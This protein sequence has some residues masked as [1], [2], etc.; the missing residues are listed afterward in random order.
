LEKENVKNLMAFLKN[1]VSPHFFMN[2]LNNIHALVDI[3]VEQAKNAIIELSQLM[4][5]MLYESQSDR[6]SLKKELE[7]VKSYVELMQLRFTDD[8]D[9]AIE[10]PADL[11]N[12][13]VPPLLTVSFIENAFKFGVSYEH[14]SFV[15]IKYEFE[16]DKLVFVCQNSLHESKPKHANSGIGLENS[17]QRIELIYGDA[18]W[19]NIDE[20]TNN[21]IFT[22]SLKTPL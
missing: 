2:T 1:Q 9:I 10:I 5:Y 12:V 19:L 13:V 22:V 4:G 16:D 14:P 3:N 7:F 20:D 8:V 18:H 11:P 21:N 6:V 17:R 15:H